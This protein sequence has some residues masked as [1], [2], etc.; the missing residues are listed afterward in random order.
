M[1]V[2]ERV[3]KRTHV[4]KERF[5]EKPSFPSD[6]KVELTAR[7][8]L[9]CV[10]CG[11][12]D[13]LRPKGD[14]PLEDFRKLVYQ[15][16]DAGV[17][18]MGL[19]LLGESFLLPNLKDYIRT[20]KKAGIEYVYITTNGTAC[21][22]MNMLDAMDA[23]L[24]SIKFSLNAGNRE[25]YI[26]V[27]GVDGFDK[28]VSAI[29][30]MAENRNDTINVCV[31]CIYFE[32]KKEESEKLKQFILTMIDDFYFLP[33]MCHG[34]YARGYCGNIGRLEN[35]VPPIP[36]WELFNTSRVTW[37]GF[38]TMCC[39]DHEGKFKIANIKDIPDHKDPLI[40]AWNHKRF[41]QLRKE[42][43]EGKT[44]HS[45]CGW[46]LKKGPNE[47]EEYV[48]GKK[49]AIIGN[50][51]RKFDKEDKYDIIVRMNEADH[52]T[53]RTDILAMSH[54]VTIGD[55]EI[56][57]PKFNLWMT[58]KRRDVKNP[59]SEK[60]Y[61]YPMKHWEDLFNKLG[62][63]PSTGCMVVDYFSKL[64]CQWDIFGFSFQQRKEMKSH[65]AEAEKKY[66]KSLK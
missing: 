58:R 23:G 33:N 22:P 65:N 16:K 7:C 59:Y 14:M 43:L 40:S 61:Y 18:E 63:R 53:G 9:K 31:S 60:M 51:N 20:A 19:F 45:L 12:K 39:F 41:I 29:R 8:N 35:L 38:L 27:T 10:N 1:K 49:V 21:N 54:F 52:S 17:K 6:M 44:E 42:H 24:D 36:C 34:G 30:W 4:P 46:C 62:S 47:L 55:Y 48:R 13:N 66:I 57:K 15:A 28:V 37:D 26:K 64:D 11:V 2:Y 32:D 25:D 56:I 50:A 3:D 5:T